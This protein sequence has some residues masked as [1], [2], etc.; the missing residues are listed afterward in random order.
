MGALSIGRRSIARLAVLLLVAG[1]AATT[2]AGATPPLEVYGKL[3]GFEAAAIS[4]SGNR[5]AI[6]GMLDGERRMLVVDGDGHL[7]TTAQLDDQKLRSIRWASEDKILVRLSWTVPL[8]AGFTAPKAELSTVLVVPATGGKFWEIFG[9]DSGITGGVRGFYG[10][11]IV[12]GHLYGYFGG[13]EVEGAD[14]VNRG[15]MNGHPNLYRV[16]LESGQRVKIANRTDQESD[17]DWVVGADGKVAAMLELSTRSGSWSLHNPKSG[18][19]ASGTSLTGDVDLI[20]LGRTPDSV[21]YLVR[22]PETAATHWFE[23]PLSGGTGQEILATEAPIGDFVDPSTGQLIGYVREGDIP[24]DHFF[25]PHRE[26]VMAAARKAFPGLSVRLMSWNTAFDKLI[27]RTDGPGD[28]QTW[29]K[30]DIKTGAAAPIGTSYPMADQDVGPMRMYRYS[31]SDGLALGGV[32]TLPPGRAAHNLPVIVLP[33][34]GPAARDYPAFDWWAQAFASLGY[35]VFQPNFRGSTGFGATFERAGWGEW[36]R[37][38]QTDISD[39]LAALA[40]DGIVD[41]KRACIVGASYGG[42]AAMAG[43]TL[44][45]GLYRCAVSVGGI[46]DLNAFRVTAMTQTNYAGVVYA[47]LKQSLGPFNDLKQV[48]PIAF[49]DHTDA[50]ILLIHG[51]DDTV[52]RFDQSKNMAAALQRAGKPVE[53]V[54]LTGEDHWLSKSETRLQML[55]AAVAFVEKYNPP[56]PA[57][58]H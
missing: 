4:P 52:V 31:A 15:L 32:L 6:I 45:H 55:K 50:P 39:G 35:A 19:I 41:P 38:M 36:G 20:S 42:Y 43:V 30:V 47:S 18:T 28:P 40:H 27:V 53:L 49:S 22:D 57:P 23:Q 14:P 9:H 56:D 26:K 24:E 37:K 5:V 25:D 21:I 16:D 34:G 2:Q 29:W 48:S 17:R 10:S 7:L 44:Q 11:N 46:G 13:M 8:G 33:H 58:V 3:P 51:E 12:D 1:V 54:K